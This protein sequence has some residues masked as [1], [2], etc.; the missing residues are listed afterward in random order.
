MPGLN[1]AFA[2]LFPWVVCL[3]LV[4]NILIPRLLFFHIQ[5]TAL[6]VLVNPTLE[7]H[8]I[9]LTRPNPLRKVS[10]LLVGDLVRAQ[11]N[12]SFDS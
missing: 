7:A 12:E 8:A 5:N 9:T 11:A 1:L 6:L 2:A 3:G 4:F 10:D